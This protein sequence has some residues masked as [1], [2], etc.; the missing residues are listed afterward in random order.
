MALGYTS[1]LK[2]ESVLV[3]TKPSYKVVLISTNFSQMNSMGSFF[4]KNKNKDT[5]CKALTFSLNKPEPL[6]KSYHED[7]SLQ[8]SLSPSS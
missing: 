7:Q 4:F 1:Q 6:Q 3:G 5:F 8:F 2:V